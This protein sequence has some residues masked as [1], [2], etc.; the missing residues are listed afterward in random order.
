MLTDNWK[1]NMIPA[2]RKRR[3]ELSSASDDEVVKLL[4]AEMTPVGRF[5]RPEEIATIVAFLASARNSFITGDTIE[6]SGGAERFM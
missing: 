4:G 2:V 6:A 5:A 1:Q 3:P